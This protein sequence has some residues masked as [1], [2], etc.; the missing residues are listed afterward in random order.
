MGHPRL[1][2]TRKTLSLNSARQARLP[3]TGQT[4]MLTLLT[5]RIVNNYSSLILILFILIPFILTFKELIQETFPF[6]YDP[7]RDFLFALDHVQKPTLIGPP[8]G[9]PGLF[10]GPYWIWILSVSLLISKNP[11]FAAFIILAL[12]Y[13]TLFPYILFKF[14]DTFGWKAC[15]FLW[16]IFISTYRIYTTYLW[17]PHL[18]PLFYLILTYLLLKTINLQ[19][20]NFS[21]PNIFLVGILSGL[22]LNFH[23]SFGAGV[24]FSSLIYIFVVSVIT[25]ASIKGEIYQHL[26][27]SVLSFLLFLIGFFLTTIPFFIFEIRHNYQQIKSIAYTLDQ[28]IFKNSAVVGQT[29]MSKKEIIQTLFVNKIS[30][31]L[32][33]KTEFILGFYTLIIFILFFRLIYKKISFSKS[34]KSILLYIFISFITIFLIYVSSKNPVWG[35]H[36][37]GTEIIILLLIGLVFKKSYF[38]SKHS[39][40][41]A[42]IY[43]LP[44]FFSLLNSFQL[45]PISF[46][47]FASKKH[48]TEYIYRDSKND[49]FSV[50][51]YSS[52]I[53]TYDFDYLFRW[54]GESKFNKKPVTDQNLAKYVYLVIPET[55][56]PIR[57][58]FINYKTPQKFYSTIY[59]KEFPDGT[60]VLKRE[61]LIK[62]LSD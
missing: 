2:E 59:Q 52:A 29:G 50:Y 23:I 45:D 13:F 54:L 27:K 57:E 47:S 10:Y 4:L 15:L 51:A 32:S 5:K 41:L 49:E 18:A 48:I 39:L 14:K 31:V 25:I 24:F 28:A 61:K 44:L 21:I 1:L 6:W 19:Q 7:A 40:Y 46:A 22:I 30:D 34:E 20:K 62:Q 16:I 56:M 33:I 3:K 17:H 53:Y 9:I 60:Q 12:P 42:I 36:F 38:L 8:T 11:K 43:I 35:Y 58:D 55:T 26:R 37:I